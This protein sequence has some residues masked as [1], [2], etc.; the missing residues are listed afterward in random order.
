MNLESN[1]PSTFVDADSWSV[2]SECPSGTGE[3]PT[4]EVRC[5]EC[6]ARTSLADMER[7]IC[8]GKC[9]NCKK[10]FLH[11]TEKGGLQCV[12]IIKMLAR[13]DTEDLYQCSRPT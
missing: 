6:I 8:H 1:E 5:L 4:E 3:D 12:I 7:V 11:A 13:K 2:E 9:Q 10:R